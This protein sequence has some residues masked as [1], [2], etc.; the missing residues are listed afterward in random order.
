MQP[1][2]GIDVPRPPGVGRYD[3]RVRLLLLNG[4]LLTAVAASIVAIELVGRP[5]SAVEASV[6]RYASAVGNQDLQ[7][8]LQEIA[9]DQ[10]DSWRDWIDGQL[11]NI[12]EV[13][14]VAVRAPSVISPPSE[15]TTV[16]DVNRAFPDQFYQATTRVAVEQQNGTWYLARPLLTDQ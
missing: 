9:P 16:L 1:R 4:V 13:R 15:V 7:A 2:A 6:H 12:Y 8:A 10:R 14:G 5:E 11:G 3:A